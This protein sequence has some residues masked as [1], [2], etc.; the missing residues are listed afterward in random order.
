MFQNVRT[1]AVYSAK[2]DEAKRFYTEIL[3]FEVFSEPTPQL[4]F[5]RSTSGKIFLYLEGGYTP[6][7]VDPQ[8]SRLSVFLEAEGSAR[9]T[10]DTL[11]TRGV[12]LLQEAP[13]EVGDGTACFQ[14][15]DPDGNILEVAGKA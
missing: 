15:T 6:T 2:L 14:F 9:E 8:S 5:L 4:V 7:P 10:F 1:I 13:E 3:G 12:N 11:K